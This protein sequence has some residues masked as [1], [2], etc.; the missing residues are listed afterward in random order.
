MDDPPLTSLSLT[1]VY[2][3]PDDRISQACAF[4]ALVP[5][6]LMIVYVSLIWSTRE[7]E[8]LLMFAGQMG[9]EA[10]NWLLKRSIREDRPSRTF[11]ILQ[12][13]STAI[14]I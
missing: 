4:L 12:E 1:H 13:Y 14:L 6:G 11:G 5:Q 3:N 8:I 10:L 2:Y 9:C 7:I